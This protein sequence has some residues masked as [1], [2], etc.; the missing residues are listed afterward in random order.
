[1]LVL[2]QRKHER[3]GRFN[4]KDTDDN[5]NTLTHFGQSIGDIEKFDSIGLSDEEIEEGD[6][7]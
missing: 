7:Q 5:D 6:A 3:S 2:L 4:L 1:M